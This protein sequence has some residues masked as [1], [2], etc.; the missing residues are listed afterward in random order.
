MNLGNIT[1]LLHFYLDGYGYH[2]YKLY[3]DSKNEA[4]LMFGVSLQGISVW[5]LKNR[6]RRLNIAYNWDQID[7]TD[8]DK[9]TFSVFVKN[10]IN[11]NKM[12]YFTN[13]SKK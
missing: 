8:F 5:E 13:N 3:K 9:R 6:Q 11:D 12:K 7:R 10:P 4:L 1:T 2:I